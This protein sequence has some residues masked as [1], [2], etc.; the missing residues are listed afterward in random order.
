MN[1]KIKIDKAF[2]E[3]G[4]VDLR[5]LTDIAEGIL[6]IAEGALQIRL[7]GISFS[8]GRKVNYLNDALA[9]KFSGIHKGS[10]VIEF[11]CEPFQQTIG[12]LQYDLFKKD[13]YEQLL[14]ETPIS[15]VVKSFTAALDEKASKDFLDKSLLYELKQFNNVFR[16]PEETLLFLNQGTIPELLLKRND[17][18]KIE[19]LEKETPDPQ[20]IILNGKI[21]VLEYSKTRAKIITKDGLVEAILGN[22]IKSEEI[23]NYWGEEV[24]IIGTAN[25][26]PGGN[27]SFVQIEKIFKPGSSDEYFS[28]K[29][30][31]EN[32]EQQIS[33]QIKE[34]YKRGNPLKDIVGKWPGDES[35]EEFELMLKDLNK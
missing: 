27:I 12:K 34:K 6:H 1:Y 26:K 35:D 33:N 18:N 32:V 19:I 20:N 23:R 31:S 21:D 29:P 14:N 4:K 22:A 13:V 10:T 3:E 28:F 30:K 24:T 7:T 2:E 9:I 17:F 5:R 16:S 15:L 11:E 8:K 25:Y